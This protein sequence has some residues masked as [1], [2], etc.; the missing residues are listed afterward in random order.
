MDLTLTPCTTSAPLLSFQGSEI[1]PQ[2]R[3]QK[4]W[5]ETHFVPEC[6][7]ST[8][9]LP[10]AALPLTI[11]SVSTGTPGASSDLVPR[12][13]PLQPPGTFTQVSA[14]DTSQRTMTGDTSAVGQS[15]DQLVGKGDGNAFLN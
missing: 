8:P 12:Q 9:P 13:G 6:A 10:S 4:L 2:V 7:V 1:T 15:A 11:A 3:P 14:T 5:T